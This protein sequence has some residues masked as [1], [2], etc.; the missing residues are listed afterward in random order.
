MNAVLLD[1]ASEAVRLH[2]YYLYV[3]GLSVVLNNQ[4]VDTS[5]TQRTRAHALPPRSAVVYGSQIGRRGRKWNGIGAPSR[6]IR[7]HE[8]NEFYAPEQLLLRKNRAPPPPVA[9]THTLSQ[10][11]PCKLLFGMGVSKSVASCLLCQAGRGGRL[12]IGVVRGTERA[13]S[14]HT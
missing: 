4:R 11:T 5:H 13:V 7:H 6:L 3:F 10:R 1:S 14:C 12:E 9:A 2:Q 8:K